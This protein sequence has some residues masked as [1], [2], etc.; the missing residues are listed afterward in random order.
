MFYSN[1]ELEYCKCKYNAYLYVTN[2][3]NS[4]VIIILESH[5]AGIYLAELQK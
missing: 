5:Q 4:Y 1:L 3:G 2:I